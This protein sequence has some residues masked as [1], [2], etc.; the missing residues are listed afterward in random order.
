NVVCT[1]AVDGSARLAVVAGGMN[2]EES[3]NATCS[4]GTAPPAGEI[5]HCRT[6]LASFSEPPRLSS[7]GYRLTPTTTAQSSAAIRLDSFRRWMLPD[8][9]PRFV[10]SLY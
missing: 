8:P 9:D 5:S 7:P 1:V 3:R 10:S 4:A 6:A 2:C